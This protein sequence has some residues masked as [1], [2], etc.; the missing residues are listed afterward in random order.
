LVIT[1]RPEQSAVGFDYPECSCAAAEVV[2]MPHLHVQAHRDSGEVSWLDDC[3]PPHSGRATL[4][5]PPAPTARLS[6][7]LPPC[8]PHGGINTDWAGHKCATLRESAK[9]AQTSQ[10]QAETP[11]PQ[12]QP[13]K[14]KADTGGT[15]GQ[16]ASG[17]HAPKDGSWAFE[18]AI[19][20]SLALAFVV[21]RRIVLELLFEDDVGGVE[22]DDAV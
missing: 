10:T 8:K 21:V 14:A 18:V 1:L 7:N 9:A 19:V 11:K 15:V 6:V 4:F 5:Q 17:S 16:A 13:P 12:P 22:R 2:A 20:L 3:P